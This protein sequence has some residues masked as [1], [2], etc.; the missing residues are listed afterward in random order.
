MSNTDP[1][2]TLGR[3]YED[4]V[5]ILTD[6]TKEVYVASVGMEFV[7]FSILQTQGTFV[8]YIQTV[9][10]T[11]GWRGK[12]VGSRI[13]QAAE[14]RIF[15]EFPNSFITVSSFNPGAQRLYERLGYEVIGE[16]KDFIIRGHSELLMR[17][18]VAPLT[19]FSP[20]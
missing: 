6:P 8:G 1:W 11:A 19:E 9:A 15:G 7:G 5:K 13:I 17:K 4:S 20:A 14:D 16:L 18:T 3:T 12:G 2:I 10:V